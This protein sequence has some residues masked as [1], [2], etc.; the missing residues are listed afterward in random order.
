MLALPGRP[1]QRIRGVKPE[2]VNSLPIDVTVRKFLY[3]GTPNYVWEGRMVERD[4]ELVVLEAYFARDRRDLGYV[5]FER[6][7][8][9]IEFYYFDRWYN[10]FQI[11]S[12]TG[13][14]K[15]WYCNITKPATLLDG[16]IRFTDMA[17]DLFAYPDGN[18]LP[19]DVEEFEQHATSLY[20]PPDTERA[21]AAFEELLVLHRAGKL[22]SR[23]FPGPTGRGG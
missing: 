8:L 17:L 12:A 23:S 3:D 2:P 21:R 19:L 13:E 4:D 7:D 22:P 16:E 20:S 15:G 1:R 14:L 6:R 11:Y 9:F 18:S 5:V 10:V